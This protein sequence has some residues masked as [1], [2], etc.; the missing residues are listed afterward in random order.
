MSVIIN[1]DTV[2]TVHL[3]S[4][5]AF[6]VRN[7]GDASLGPAGR[8]AAKRGPQH[9]D[10]KSGHIPDIHI[11]P[12]IVSHMYIVSHIDYIHVRRVYMSYVCHKGDTKQT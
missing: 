11:V 9:P 4:M 10:Q 5:Y 7:G 12:D 1:V 3:Q 8:R 2:M 6:C